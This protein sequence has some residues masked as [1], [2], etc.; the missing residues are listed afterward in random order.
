MQASTAN[1]CLRKLSDWVNSVSKPPRPFAITHELF[2]VFSWFSPV[3][4]AFHIRIF[5]LGPRFSLTSTGYLPQI[6]SQ[7][8]IKDNLIGS[9]RGPLWQLPNLNGHD[10]CP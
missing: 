1:A 10:S 5:Y 6:T 2:P 9:R 7:V 8:G 4:F 3:N